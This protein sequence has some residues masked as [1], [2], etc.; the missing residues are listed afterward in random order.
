MSVM[1]LAYHRVA[2]LERDS[3]A[4]AVTPERFAEQLDALGTIGAPVPLS[5]LRSVEPGKTRFAFTFD[6]GYADN[7]ENAR[8]LLADRGW[9][10]TLF[11]TTGN[12]RSGREFWWDELETLLFSPGTLPARFDT[13]IPRSNSRLS[14]EG[15][16]LTEEEAVASRS[17]SLLSA[18]DAAPREQAYRKTAG[19][20]RNAHPD[21]RE[22]L[23]TQIRAWAEHPNSD[24]RESHRP[25]TVD[26]VSALAADEVMDVGAHTVSHPA[27]AA[28]SPR[29]Q[30]EELAASKR[31]LEELVDRPVTSFAY[32]YGNRSLLRDV[33][34]KLTRGR[35]SA[36]NSY[37][38]TS[39]RLI[40]EA[41]FQEAWTT[42]PGTVTPQ[43]DR[44]QLPRILV[45]DWSGDELLSRL[46]VLA[47]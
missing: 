11:I 19:I 34:N 44:F 9:P 33:M 30:R 7:I 14:F 26:E 25:M 35:R 18:R 3:Q 4:L 12:V 27:L 39:S 5:E 37:T 22:E 45:R 8:P 43:S 41:G 46:T 15:G 2:T 29:E 36:P 23:L 16:E 1:V 31:S 24:P 47:R 42:R 17:W 38:A 32:P 6:D 28:L 40:Q 20:L 10:A 21:V 13:Q